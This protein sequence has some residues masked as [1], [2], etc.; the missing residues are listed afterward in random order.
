MK[1]LFIWAEN[2]WAIGKIHHALER[3][4][5]NEFEF[6][7]CDWGTC[8]DKNRLQNEF[9]TCDLFMS[10]YVGQHYTSQH[11][12]GL[13]MKKCVFVS[14]GFEEMQGVDPSPLATYGIVSHS[15]EHLFPTNLK[16]FFVPNCVELDDYTH[17]EHS[18]STNVVGWCGA[19]HIWFKQFHWAR[20]IAKQL[21]TELQVS[22]KVPF[23][24]VADWK[25]LSSEELKEWYSKIDILL[26]TSIPNGQSE[27]GPL[28]AFEAIASG[29]VVIGTAVGNFMEVPGPKF[30]TV[31]EAVSILNELKNDPERVKQIAKEQYNCI[32]QNWNYKVVSEKWREMFHSALKNSESS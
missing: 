16:P 19:P 27:T 12:P 10:C 7:Y 13:N 8:E 28:P 17:K 31:E 9:N 30:A 4:L 2:G 20:E 23:E 32:V 21:G 25:S 18:G 6:I 5:S 14:H 3:Y 26:I 22:S 11:F 15:I 29:V 1:K 24:D